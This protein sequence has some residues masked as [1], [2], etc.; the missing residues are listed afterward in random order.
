LQFISVAYSCGEILT[1]GSIEQ[2]PDSTWVRFTPNAVQFLLNCGQAKGLK[3]K[4]R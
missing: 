2:D 4:R 1:Y 3:P